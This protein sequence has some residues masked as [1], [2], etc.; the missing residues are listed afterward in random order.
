VCFVSFLRTEFNRLLLR[1]ALKTAR[2]KTDLSQDWF[3]GKVVQA[4]NIAF[5]E[6]G[7]FLGDG[8]GSDL[9]SKGSVRKA[10]GACERP[11][12][13]ADNLVPEEKDL[14]MLERLA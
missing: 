2:D 8:R 4:R 6:E 12:L 7:E 3:A 14:L 9:D 5:L 13:I 11:E 1:G 10:N